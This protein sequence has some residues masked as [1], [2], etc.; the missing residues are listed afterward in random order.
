MLI[1][2]IEGKFLSEK[3][4]KENTITDGNEFWVVK[5]NDLLPFRKNIGNQSNVKTDKLFTLLISHICF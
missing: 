1:V 2:I 3:L 5:V 4:A